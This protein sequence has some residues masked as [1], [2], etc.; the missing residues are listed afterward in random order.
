MQKLELDYKYKSVGVIK[1]S[2]KVLDFLL[3]LEKE[4]RKAITNVLEEKIEKGQFQFFTYNFNIETSNILN[5]GFIYRIHHID[6]YDVDDIIITICEDK[7]DLLEYLTKHPISMDLDTHEKMLD[8][9][10]NL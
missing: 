10:E 6:R 3:T 1:G 4:Q 5:K 2:D 8:K 9:I 7:E